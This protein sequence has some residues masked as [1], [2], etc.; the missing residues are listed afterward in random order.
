M[1]LKKLLLENINPEVF[2]QIEFPGVKFREGRNSDVWCCFHKE[3][4]GE[5]LSLD[6]KGKWFCHSCQA[7]GGNILQFYAERYKLSQVEASRELFD[8][9]VHPLVDEKV[10][11]KFTRQLGDTPSA[12]VYIVKQRLVEKNAV[13]RFKIGWN[14]TRITFPVY[15]EYGLCVNVR[16]YDPL[17]KKK[18][19]PKVI[20]YSERSEKN[21]EQ[22]SFGSPAMLWPLEVLYQCKQHGKQLV[23][24]EGEFDCLLLNSLGI[25]AVTSTSGSSAWPQQYNK[26]FQDMDVVMCYDN[27]EPDRITKTRAG[28]EGEKKIIENIGSLVFSLRK[29]RIPSTEIKDVTGWARANRGMRTRAGWLR[30]IEKS[31]IIVE[32]RKN[33]QKDLPPLQVPLAQASEASW[34]NRPITVK[35]I[36]IGKDLAPYMLPRKY[37]VSCSKPEPCDKCPVRLMGE[38]SLS[39]EI[40]PKDPKVLE[41][42]D[43]TSS[44]IE[45]ELLNENGISPECGG[46]IE[47]EK[48]FN[49]EQLVLTPALDTGDTHAYVTRSAY[50]VGHGLVPNRTYNFTGVTVPHPSDQ[51]ATHLFVGKDAVQDEIETFKLDEKTNGLLRKIFAVRPGRQLM[52]HLNQLADWQSRH[53]TK[54]KARPDLHLAIDLVYHS[55][56]AMRFN[57]EE[58]PRAMLD[59]LIIG[60]TRCGKGYVAE[61]LNKFYGF[62]EVA[63]GENCTFAGLIGGL[64]QDNKRWM[65][66]WGLIP[67]NHN[68]LV[69]IDEAS[70]LTEKDIGHMSRVRSEGIAEI[71]KIR[72]EQV[73]ANT[74]LVW[75]SNPRSGHQLMG[76]KYNSGV[77]SIKEL[78]GANEDISRFDFAMTVAKNEVSPEIINAVNPKEDNSDLE[79]YPHSAARKLV[80]WAWS[81]TKDQI[82]FTEQAIREVISLAIRLGN[83]YSSAIPLVQAENIRIKIAKIAAAVAARVYSSDVKGEKLIIKSEHV[84]FVGDFLEMVYDKPSMG[85]DNFSK[86][87]QVSAKI[88][89][90]SAVDKVFKSLDA[91][92]QSAINGL[93]ELSYIDVANLADYVGDSITSKALIGELVKLH[94]LAR[95]KQ[96][97]IKSQAFISWLKTRSKK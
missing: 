69:I 42:V 88:E 23:I 28:E 8:R 7:G 80:L 46:K 92:A 33:A 10:I 65:V 81:R 16:M 76:G 9:Y 27:D 91:D 66:T 73:V 19:R 39:C 71:N 62:G 57:N 21:G 79:K 77:E 61:R 52:D 87:A 5:S 2:W 31:E 97:Y 51:H 90:I 36:C 48:A 12:F 13:S 58:I 67:M 60:D 75:L 14:G 56:P 22:R 24:C 38:K 72:R 3:R 30:E 44:Q 40:D 96:G 85:Y 94:C 59:V 6:A 26:M 68:R 49:L 41:L 86:L 74:R 70:S 93:G 11:R 55:V 29:L 83:K 89:D 43:K 63:S 64:Q 15:N 95:D 47:I 78:M 50:L 84:K 1:S 37:N 18:N 20:N 53:I 34:Y 25:P 35:A 32:N 82:V 4:K 54:I 17:A 45:Q